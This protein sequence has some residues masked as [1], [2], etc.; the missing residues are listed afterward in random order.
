MGGLIMASTINADT[1]N[2]VVVTSDTSGEIELQS[3]GVTKAK[4][5]SSGLQNASGVAITAQSGKNLI[6]NGNMAIAQRGTSFSASTSALYCLDRF[7]YISVAGAGGSVYTITQDTDAPSGFSNSLKIDVATADTSI[8]ANEGTQI[9]HRIEGQNLQ[10][11]AFG[12]SDAKSLTLSFWVKSNKTGTYV[13]RLLQ[14]DASSRMISQA[15]TISS[16]NTWE[17]KTITVSGDTS[18]VIND[19]NGAG[20]H[21]T[22]WL[23][24]GTDYQSGS[25][26]TDWQSY[27][28]GDTA[29]GQVNLADSTSNYLNIAGVQLE[30]G[31]TATPFEHLQY[32][33]QLALCQRYFQVIGGGKPSAAIFGGDASS[34]SNVYTHI[35]LFGGSMRSSPTVTEEGS[36]NTLN[37]GSRS[38]DYLNTMSISLRVSP[39]GA[40]RYYIELDSS[41]DRILLSSE[42]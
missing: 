10:Q 1:T 37:I 26:P 25:M 2:G 6:I 23:T 30:T 27:S 9:E 42:L 36:F 35:P 12:T 33:Q 11:L 17:K 16:A 40:G 4:V 31:T 5:T 8:A 29:V 7:Y 39:N 34:T 28:N 38:F 20:L 22:W 19:D 14:P 15:Y 32:G 21:I 3:A 13:A 24:A 41:D 18:G